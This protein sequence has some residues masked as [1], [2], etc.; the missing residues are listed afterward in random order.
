[1]RKFIGKV[2]SFFIVLW[3]GF[4]LRNEEFKQGGLK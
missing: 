4:K 1:M 3:V 2:I